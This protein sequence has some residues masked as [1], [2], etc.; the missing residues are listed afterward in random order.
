VIRYE[1]IQERIEAYNPDADFDL[2]RRAYVFSAREHR[3]QTR[4][5]GEPYLIHP[6]EVAGILA[7]LRL[8]MTCI[9][10]G[11]LHDVVEDTLVG[12]DI[13]EKYFGRDIAH[14]VAGVT[15]LSK[16]D[17]RSKEE[18][19][20]ENLRKMLL[21]MVDDIRVILVKLADRL[22]NMRTLGFL[23][24]AKQKEIARETRDIY[25]PIAHRLG[26]GR[27]KSE[28]EDLC[29]RYLSPD[30]YESL[31]GQLE[32]KRR[33]SADFIEEIHRR[34][35]DAVSGQG[36]SAEITGRIKS[37]ASIHEKMERQSVDVDE[38]YD[39]VAFRLLVPTVKDCYGAL[40]IIH[41]LWRP[42][43][44]RFR[45][46]VAM[47][48]PNGYQSLH[49]SVMSSRGQPF[50][51]QIRTPEMHRVAEEGIAAHWSYKAG[52]RGAESDDVSS[53]QWLRQYLD[54]LQDVQD[55][56]E[57][58]QVARMDLYPEEVYAFTPRGDVK[59]F[60][61]GATVL[62]FAYAI[63]TDIGHQCVGAR[64]NGR[65]VAVRT[66]IANGDIVEILTSPTRHPSRD[67][68]GFARTSR[69][70]SKIRQWLNIHE[71]QKSMA[72]GRDVAEREFRKYRF[73]PKRYPDK[74]LR[75]ALKALGFEAYDDFLVAVGY[76]KASPGA[77][78]GRLDPSLR[79]QDRPESRLRKV[80]KR[81]LGVGSPQIEVD[82]VDDVMV[83]VAGCCAPIPGEEIVGYV[84]R[85]RGVSVHSAD[86][87]NV[88][89]LLYGS[90]RRIDVAWSRRSGE[91]V[92]HPVRVMVITDEKQGVLAR[93]TNAISEDGTNINT[94]EARVSENR[95]G[96]ILLVLDI[97]DVEHLDRVL[98]RLR[99]IEGIR[100][101]ER[102]AG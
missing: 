71:R 43:P 6:L 80:V 89:S 70:R 79:P 74:Q 37:A 62:D 24:P 45:D 77:L 59:S 93:I 56:R 99:S 29:L 88:Q 28:L 51:V 2:L 22:H 90:E 35:Q 9:V 12:M 87:A 50:E 46:Y 66:E 78:V 94:V 52:A 82:G 75:Q 30:E 76:G 55:P 10:V 96:T 63:H 32:L 17:F 85:G 40:G 8:D 57:F 39:Y 26:M 64:I 31:M 101:A 15:K 61:R 100:H 98:R 54:L 11:L 72:V 38:V 73:N 34:I 18:Q 14:I 69:A 36:I 1:D 13:I 60:P 21:A 23:S 42:V 27:I 53:V 48:K 68:L 47:P 4:H 84:T 91:E 58:L 16:L 19:Q 65:F 44:G 33:V 5:S 3:G 49:T 25:A 92:T 102:H 95:Q 20:A 81:A 7:D 83:S 41:S 67:S 97:R 86:C